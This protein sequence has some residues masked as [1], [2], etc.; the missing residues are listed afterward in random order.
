[1]VG[2]GATLG[3]FAARRISAHQAQ[4]V[5]VFLAVAGSLVVLARGLITLA[6]T[7]PL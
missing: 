2:I 3:T 6:G 4:K 1:M 5:S 7:L